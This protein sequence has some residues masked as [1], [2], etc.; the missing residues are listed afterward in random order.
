MIYLDNAATTYPKPEVV[1]EEMDRVNR[2]MAFNSGRGS[3]KEARFAS[4]LIEETRQLLVDLVHGNGSEKVVLTSSATE[5]LNIILQGISWEEGDVAY[6]SPFEHNAVARVLELVKKEK[7]I[8]VELL[9]VKE[10]SLEIDL[11]KIEFLFLKT[12][13]KCVCCTHI[14]NVIGY[15][16]P[17]RDIFSIAHSVGAITVLDAS[18]SMGLIDIKVE[19]IGADFIS[20][21]GHK[22]LYGPF[23]IG[24]FID[25][26]EIPLSSVFVGGTGSDS[27]NLDMPESSPGK[28]ET[29]SK[30]IVAIS[31]LRAS[32]SSLNNSLI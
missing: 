11:D 23:G 3:Y 20:F 5:A 15:V 29:A 6:I 26:R 8:Q 18:Q 14:S 21:A 19:D 27:L 24:G 7:K 28:Y 13:P 1:Y 22:T 9:P 17:V 25:V 12:K 32:L 2:E 30:N 4:N 16:L 31:G 10:D